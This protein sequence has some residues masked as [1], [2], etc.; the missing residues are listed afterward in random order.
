M[1]GFPGW[2]RELL[3]SLGAP[4]T[5]Q[6]LRFLGAWQQAEGGS[7][8]YN[9]LNTTQHAPGAGSYN[10]VGVR[11]YTSAQQGLHATA[12]TLSDPRYQQIVGGLRSGRASATQLAQSVARSPWGTGALILKVLG[13]GAS[14]AT[15]ALPAAS[16]PAQ[17]ATRPAAQPAPR[18]ALA[19]NLIANLGMI[20]QHQTPDVSQTARLVAQLQPTTP[21]GRPGKPIPVVADPGVGSGKANQVVKLAEHFLGTKYVWGGSKPGGF[22]CSGLLQYVW[23]R[24]GVS[25]PRTSQ[26]QFKAG[27]PVAK[28]QLRPGD[29]V[30]FEGSAPGH[31]G[32]Y[33]G[34]GKFIEAPHTG[35]VVRIS[36]LAGRGDYVGARRFI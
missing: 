14:G 9:P 19:Q 13:S 25:I 7:A 35:A 33:V 23:G 29:A 5:P 22:D 32:M 31:V 15:Q 1:S 11:S 36:T 2:E 24:R 30:F 12:H 18:A 6:N 28:G 16:L 20:G 10:S 17:A 4:A 8:A 34:G 3:R 27:R 21:S 26:Q